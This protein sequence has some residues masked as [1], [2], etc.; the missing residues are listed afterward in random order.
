VKTLQLSP[1][2]PLS[3]PYTPNQLRVRERKPDGG[4]GGEEGGKKAR[5]K[6]LVIRGRV[7]K[8][9]GVG[10]DDPMCGG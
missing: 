2:S 4:G 8:G 9:G 5:E 6:S 7:E 1:H 10:L 3:S